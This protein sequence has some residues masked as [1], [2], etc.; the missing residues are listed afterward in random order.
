MILNLTNYSGNGNQGQKVAAA[1]YL[2]NLIR[3]NIYGED[4]FPSF[5]KEF[6]DK[7]LETLLRVE[8]PVLRI[9][10]EAVPLFLN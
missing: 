6:K 1:T 9:L 4:Q 2:K 7:L 5:S 10:V 3:R 8:M